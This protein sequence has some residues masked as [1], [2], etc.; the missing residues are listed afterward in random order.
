MSVAE[1]IGFVELLRRGEVENFNNGIPALCIPPLTLVDGPD[2]VAAGLARVTQL[3]AA[4]ALAATFDKSLAYDYGKVLGGEARAKGFDAVQAPELNLAQVA[5]S[6]RT[7]EAF[8]EDPLLT[9]VMGVAEA[10]G[11]QSRGE[12]AVAKHFTAYNQETDRQT[13]REVVSSARWRSCTTGL[14]KPW[15]PRRTWPR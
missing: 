15:S 9:S 10:R 12:M 14:S 2:G 1:K 5:Q 8:G 6:G 11:I 13:L 3:P 7:F 4:I